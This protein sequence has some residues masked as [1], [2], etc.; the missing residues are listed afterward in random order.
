M[1]KWLLIFI[2]LHLSGC[3]L[4][5]T[6]VLYNNTGHDFLFLVLRDHV[7]IEEVEVKNNSLVEINNWETRNY[8]INIRD[9][10][11]KYEPVF[12]HH[13]FVDFSGWGPWSKR[14]LHAQIEPDGRIFVLNIGQVPPVVD[15]PDQPNGFPMIPI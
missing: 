7:V 6:C 8:Q 13:E 14:K 10:T 2:C 12:F 4:P 9:S 11:S 3:T 1:K 15:F 5:L